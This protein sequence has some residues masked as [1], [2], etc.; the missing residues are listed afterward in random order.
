MECL[1][2]QR[3]FAKKKYLDQHMKI[4]NSQKKFECSTCHK[5]FHRKANKNHHEKI[6][7]RRPSQTSAPSRQDLHQTLDEVPE[8]SPAPG[9]SQR[10]DRRVRSA[11]EP[12]PAKRPRI[13]KIGGQSTSRKCKVHGPREKPKTYCVAAA[14]KPATVTW[15]LIRPKDETSTVATLLDECTL[16]MKGKLSRY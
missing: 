6:H 2:C 10:I 14:F 4:H 1:I 5:R 15:K 11:S 16:D 13:E 3:K 7:S 9:P 8:Q 12:P